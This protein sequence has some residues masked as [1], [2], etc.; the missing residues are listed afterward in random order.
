MNPWQAAFFRFEADPARESVTE[1]VLKLKSARLSLLD[2]PRLTLSWPNVPISRVC[3]VCSPD[4][5][6]HSSVHEPT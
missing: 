1:G 4:R 3:I 6:G 5:E 2:P